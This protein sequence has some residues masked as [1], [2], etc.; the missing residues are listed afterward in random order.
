M[1][2]GGFAINWFDLGVVGLLALGMYRGRSRGM[3][4]EL[5]DVVKW[6][7][8]V[9]VGGMIYRPVGRFAAGY[10]HLP[11]AVSYVA[12]YI[13]LI[14]TV[15]TVFGAIRRAAGEKLVGSDVFGNSEYYLGMMA[16]GLRFACYLIVG[17]ALLNAKHI[18]SE[19]RAAM[20]RMQQE[21]FGDISLPTLGSIQQTVFAG[22]ASGQFAKRYLAGQLIVPDASDPGARR[23]DTIGRQ[24]ERAI[25]EILG[26]KK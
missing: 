19:E 2:L 17:M 15:R 22:S 14:I 25:S 3:S 18:S 26:E 23:G 9:V 21:N 4:E 10:V 11:V 16:G 24:R 6:L 12:V 1:D 13:L 5:L 8:I 20:A 7:V